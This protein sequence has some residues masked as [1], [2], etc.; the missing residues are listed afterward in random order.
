MV[1][2]LKYLG[3]L[4]LVMVCPLLY[5]SLR[6]KTKT[7]V[8]YVCTRSEAFDHKTIKFWTQA[9]SMGSK[10]M[11]GVIGKKQTEMV[12]N[13]SSIFCVDEV[14]AEAPTKADLMFLEKQRID[15]VVLTSDQLSQT[16]F[17]TDEVKLAGKCIT[18]GEDHVFRPLKA[19]DESKRA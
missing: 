13:A 6:N 19:K 8:I 3:L 17:V 4:V 5:K 7:R 2:Y 18:L 15:Y 16:P 1:P 12:M 10:L 11:V 9:R 14:I